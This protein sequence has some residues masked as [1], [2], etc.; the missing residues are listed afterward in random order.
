M[1]SLQANEPEKLKDSN[2]CKTVGLEGSY[3]E[4]RGPP[5]V[6]QDPNAGL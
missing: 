2:Y 4:D 5:R 6:V 1:F 3:G